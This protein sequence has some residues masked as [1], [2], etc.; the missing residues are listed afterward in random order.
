[1]LNARTLAPLADRGTVAILLASSWR[2]GL[3]GF[4]RQASQYGNESKRGGVLGSAQALHTSL[5]LVFFNLGA[6][7]ET[8]HPAHVMDGDIRNRRR[9]VMLQP[10]RHRFRP[11]NQERSEKSGDS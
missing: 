1:M 9:H 5:A 7:A 3:F 6:A 2:P 11:A 8:R 4:I 10:S